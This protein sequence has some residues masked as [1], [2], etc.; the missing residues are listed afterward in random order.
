MSWELVPKSD[1]IFKVWP[2]GDLQVR[3][4]GKSACICR[5]KALIWSLGRADM[6]RKRV[7]GFGFFK[8]SDRLL[9]RSVKGVIWALSC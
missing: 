9:E 7:L 6:R 5:H 4:S 8:Y 1:W 3:V 2:E